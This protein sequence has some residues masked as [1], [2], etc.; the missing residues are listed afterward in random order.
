MRPTILLCGEGEDAE[1]AAAFATATARAARLTSPAAARQAA[2]VREAYR[3]AC[4]ALVCDASQ[5]PALR[6]TIESE[7]LTPKFELVSGPQR[8]A[9]ATPRALRAL[10]AR[11]YLKARA[12]KS[13]RTP[14]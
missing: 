14:V 10:R 12:D 13:A 4:N 6:L 8:G 5:R 11:A 1:A 9:R 2:R 7:T 3:A